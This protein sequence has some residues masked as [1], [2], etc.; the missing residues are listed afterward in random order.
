[1]GE[2]DHW[3]LG[4]VGFNGSARSREEV[5]LWLRRRGREEGEQSSKRW[6]LE[7]DYCVLCRGER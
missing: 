2:P 6:N 5:L 1:M 4:W 3:V 7:E